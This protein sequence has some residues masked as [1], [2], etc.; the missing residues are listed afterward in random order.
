M[1][2]GR[3]NGWH[4]SLLR[5]ILTDMKKSTIWIIVVALVVI[6]GVWAWSDRGG[7]D[8]QQVPGQTAAQNASSTADGS[9]ALAPDGGPTVVMPAQPGTPAPHIPA[10]APTGVPSIIITYDNAQGFTPSS[11]TVAEGT[12]VRFINQ[13]S[14]AKLSVT[15][16]PKHTAPMYP[17]FNEPGSI[18]P[19]HYWDFNFTKPGV[20]GYGDYYNVTKSFHGV[21]TV[22]VPTNAPKAQ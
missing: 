2:E 13:S 11:V 14:T 9:G 21:V 16:D 18:L 19:G 3:R 6:I 17:Q 4:G 5:A 15:P 8:D 20:W 7:A 10:P 12:T 22:T 1:K